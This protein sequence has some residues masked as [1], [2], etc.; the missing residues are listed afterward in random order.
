VGRIPDDLDAVA[1]IRLRL[2]AFLRER[3]PGL[4]RVDLA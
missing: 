2:E 1:G 4:E 3:V